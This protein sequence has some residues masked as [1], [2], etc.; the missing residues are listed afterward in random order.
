[1]NNTQFNQAAISAKIA[2]NELA[3]KA[4]KLHPYI[5]DLV[6]TQSDNVEKHLNWILDAEGDESETLER[7]HIFLSIFSSRY[8]SDDESSTQSRESFLKGFYEVA[9]YEYNVSR[10]H[11]S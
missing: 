4:L 9:L 5:L 7:C 6:D 2:L 3:I 8:R 11:A 1:M 10:M